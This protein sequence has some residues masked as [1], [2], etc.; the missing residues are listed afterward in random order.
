MNKLARALVSVLLLAAVG[1]V[2]GCGGIS[3]DKLNT[4]QFWEKLAREGN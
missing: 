2:A 4:E 3:A 1:V